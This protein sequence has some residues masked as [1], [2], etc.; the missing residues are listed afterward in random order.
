MFPVALMVDGQTE[1][2]VSVHETPKVGEIIT[3]YDTYGK[4]V[5]K[6]YAIKHLCD[7]GT[8]IHLIGVNVDLLEY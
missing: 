2:E 4:R 7:S 8:G 6:V 3:L 5:Y 1:A